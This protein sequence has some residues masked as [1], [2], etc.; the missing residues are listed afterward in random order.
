MLY[1][2]NDL[3]TFLLPNTDY[4][5]YKNDLDFFCKNMGLS[6]NKKKKMRG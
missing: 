3:I 2:L 1:Y 4:T 6:N 5:T